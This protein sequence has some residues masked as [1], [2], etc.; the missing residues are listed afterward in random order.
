MDKKII[1]N[2]LEYKSYRYSINFISLI[3]AVFLICMM[4]PLMYFWIKDHDLA[5]TGVYLA[6]I[7]TLFVII[8]VPILGLM[9]YYL[10]K[11]YSIFKIG[12]KMKIMEVELNNP[13]SGYYGTV[14][15]I[16]TITNS[17]NEK[18]VKQSLVGIRGH[19]FDEYNNKRVKI[20]YSEDYE[21]FFIIKN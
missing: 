16:I 5:L 6:I 2:T 7:I 18:L 8:F 3:L 12:K 20:C 19:L 17:N 9:W 1:K 13:K 21:Y 11:L 10:F 4:V 15:Y 14:H